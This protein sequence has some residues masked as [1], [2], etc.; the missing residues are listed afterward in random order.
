M[1][2]NITPAKHFEEPYIGMPINLDFCLDDFDDEMMPIPKIGD[3]IPDM[4]NV[5]PD[6][7]NILP[8]MGSMMPDM[9]DMMPDMGSMMPDMN[10]MMPAECDRISAV[11]CTPETCLESWPLAMA[12]VPMQQFENL[13]EPQE[14]FNQGTIFRDLA[15][16]FR[17]GQG[18]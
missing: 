9:N 11:N 14:G 10:D 1:N 5:M 7:G 12:Y 13:F 2:I 8:D 16:P 6:M 3:I 18:R 17:G 4:E 15:L